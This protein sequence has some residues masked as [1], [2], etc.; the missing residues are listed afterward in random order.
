M[1]LKAYAGTLA[2]HWLVVVLVPAIVLA[3]IIVQSVVM[4]RNYTASAQL[5][6]V[7]QPEPLP[8][9]EYRY[10]RYYAYVSSE[11]A[12]DD[13]VEV[14]QGNVFARDVAT[15]LAEQFNINLTPEDVQRAISATRLHRILTID[16]TSSDP[17]QAMTIAEAAAAT[18]EA[19]GL[20]YFGLDNS[21]AAPLTITTVGLPTRAEA[22]TL[23]Q[24]LIYALQVLVALVVGVLL[25]FLLDYLDD[26]FRTPEMATAALGIP[27][28]GVIPD[29]SAKQ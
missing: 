16:A 27:V 17:D 4:P 24:I 22:G 15:T 13:Y 18:L 10:D 28:I 23:R 21:D 6:V 7:F 1:E 29:G 3:A 12:L 5:S 8:T 9:P 14:V 11:Y 19:Q 26:T 20:A 25:A 2:R